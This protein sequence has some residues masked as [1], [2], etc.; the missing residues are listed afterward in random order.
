MFTRSKVKKFPGDSAAKEPIVTIDTDDYDEQSDEHASEYDAKDDADTGPA[1]RQRPKRE[2][3]NRRS[4]PKSKLESQMKSLKRDTGMR[5]YTNKAAIDSGLKG[6]AQRDRE[7][8]S[9]LPS[10]VENDR[11]T[12][13]LKRFMTALDTY[14]FDKAA[15]APSTV[16]YTTMDVLLQYPTIRKLATALHNPK[17]RPNIHFA[18]LAHGTRYN[19]VK[20]ND[21]GS[22]AFNEKTIS[23]DNMI[24]IVKTVKE[25]L[26]R[27]PGDPWGRTASKLRQEIMDLA[28]KHHGYHTFDPL[29]HPVPGTGKTAGAYGAYFGVYMMDDEGWKVKKINVSPKYIDMAK[30]IP[31]LPA[32]TT[33]ATKTDM[34][35]PSTTLLPAIST[36]R[37]VPDSKYSGQ[38]RDRHQRAID[39]CYYLSAQLRGRIFENAGAFGACVETITQ[40]TIGRR[41]K[42]RRLTGLYRG[43]AILRFCKRPG[44]ITMIKFS[45]PIL[46]DLGIKGDGPCL[47]VYSRF[48]AHLAYIL[49]V[50]DQCFLSG[51][52]LRDTM[53]RIAAAA[54]V[55]NQSIAQ[56]EVP[57]PVCSHGT[58][59]PPG[60]GHTCTSCGSHVPC[61]EVS[62]GMTCPDCSFTVR[63]IRRRLDILIREDVTRGIPVADSDLDDAMRTMPGAEGLAEDPPYATDYF[64]PGKRRYLKG[65]GREEQASPDALFGVARRSDGT[66]GYH[67]EHNV[68]PTALWINLAKSTWDPSWLA[69]AVKL[70]SA[71]SPEEYSH[72]LDV[73]EEI[74]EVSL[75]KAHNKAGRFGTDLTAAKFEM[76]EY[77][78]RSGKHFP[79]NQS[80]QEK[81]TAK[82]HQY[83]SN[84]RNPPR[85]GWKP[86]EF[87]E[88]LKP[89]VDEILNTGQRSG[90]CEVALG[91]DGCPFPGPPDAKP[92]DWN[93]WNAWCFFGERLIRMWLFC[94]GRWILVDTIETVFLSCLWCYI[95]NDRGFTGL[96]WV[97]WVRHL[98][99]L[100]LGHRF[101]GR[102]MRGYFP[103]GASSLDQLDTVNANMRF[104]TAFDNFGAHDF[105][106][107][108]IG[109]IAAEFPRIQIRQEDYDPNR[110]IPRLDPAV[111]AA[112][113]VEEHDGYVHGGM[114]EFDDDDDEE[115]EADDVDEVDDERKVQPGRKRKRSA[116]DDNGDQNNVDADDEKEAGV[117]ESKAARK[118]KLAPTAPSTRSDRRTGGQERP[119]SKTISETLAELDRLMKARG[120]REEPEENEPPTKRTRGAGAAAIT[121]EAGSDVPTG[122]GQTTTFDDDE[123]MQDNINVNMDSPTATK[124]AGGSEDVTE[125]PHVTAAK[126]RI[127]DLPI[128]DNTYEFFVST[129]YLDILTAGD[130]DTDPRTGYEKT[131]DQIN[132]L[133]FRPAGPRPTDTEGANAWDAR[134]DHHLLYWQHFNEP[135]PAGFFND[136]AIPTRSP[137]EGMSPWLAAKFNAAKQAAADAAR[138]VDIDVEMAG[139]TTTGEDDDEAEASTGRRGGPSDRGTR[140]SGS[141]A[142]RLSAP[143]ADDQAT[144]G[145]TGLPA[146]DAGKPFRSSPGNQSSD[147]GGSFAGGMSDLPDFGDYDE[148][149][150]RTKKKTSWFGRQRAVLPKGP[151]KDN[152]DKG[153]GAPEPPFRQPGDFEER[154]AMITRG[155][156]DPETST[157]LTATEIPDEVPG[158]GPMGRE[159]F[160]MPSYG[161]HLEVHNRPIPGR[162]AGQQWGAVSDGTFRWPPP[163][164][165]KRP[166]SPGNRTGFTWG[167]V[168]TAPELAIQGMIGGYD[169]ITSFG[170][171]PEFVDD[172]DPKQLRPGRHGFKWRAPADREERWEVIAEGGYHPLTE[173]G[174][175]R[176][177]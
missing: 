83:M 48:W 176:V 138:G 132:W 15:S 10:E 125:D 173:E 51:I 27:Y 113:W 177:D 54:D 52:G 18:D 152:H 81:I 78:M 93:Y 5:G 157:G 71:A 139:T 151:Y 64:L 121:D 61:T 108:A 156:W 142:G 75:K 21:L 97:L 104:E 147:P 94:N 169:P 168:F 37:I 171:L 63:S 3:I 72:L 86:L 35:G 114:V 111:H 11:E 2:T 43:Y 84:K 124:P 98:R 150:S 164:P 103:D 128:D 1:K 12:R 32:S 29:P 67:V 172:S 85:I 74:H 134:R 91:A 59:P 33:Y 49:D 76:M 6:L 115:T 24:P 57:K 158:F 144:S 130:D 25:L 109:R 153:L 19:D 23:T 141:G 117:P 7:L 149:S 135:P 77:E 137:T 148:E 120:S 8:M 105:D 73:E 95:N 39:F 92:E 154:R 60:T 20:R 122:N 161:A 87:Q 118:P 143:G 65:V 58:D 16:S 44:N 89:L 166:V 47:Y 116:N 26:E 38:E 123:L 34:D 30:Q 165:E 96:S 69:I 133:R 160:N 82:K 45:K 80:H 167:H 17:S 174:W 36:S 136:P 145:A 31:T 42:F 106:D 50:A 66:F 14:K 127:S 90:G 155:R 99:R 107:N 110:P 100:V 131:T 13:Q 22:V 146:S 129:G 79:D 175:V 40:A 46:K 112:E 68:V 53:A 70:K 101:H 9:M 163:A 4:N 88:R 140:G 170:Y 55:T 159:H 102:Q 41:S 62:L 56:G 28:K 162:P 126:K 119:G